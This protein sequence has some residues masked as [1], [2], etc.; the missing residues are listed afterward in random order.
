MKKLNVSQMENLQ[1]AV[2]PRSCLVAGVITGGLLL[3]DIAAL[4]SAFI[5]AGA[6]GGIAAALA[7]C[8]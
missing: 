3:T 8:V 1:G 7:D 5:I 4:S 2:K 6:G